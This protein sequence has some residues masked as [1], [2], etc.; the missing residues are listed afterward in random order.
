METHGQRSFLRTDPRA[1]SQPTEAEGLLASLLPTIGCPWAWKLLSHSQDF[2]QGQNYKAWDQQPLGW[3][4]GMASALHRVSPAGTAGPRPPP[5]D[6]ETEAC[7]DMI[8]D[9]EGWG[10]GLSQP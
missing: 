7:R 8:G 2:L 5:T 4:Q 1:H 3:A 9:E 10:L 6:G